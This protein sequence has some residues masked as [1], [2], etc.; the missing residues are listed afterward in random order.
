MAKTLQAK[1]RKAGRTAK[2][3]AGHKPD[4]RQSD[5][6]ASRPGAHDARNHQT[7]GDRAVHPLQEL[8][9]SAA[10]GIGLGRYSAVVA[11][12]DGALMSGSDPKV[13]S[14]PHTVDES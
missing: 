13:T 2:G 7:A 11:G 4:Y 10:P 1:P 14:C 12:A 6:T 5:P 3:V 9:A 8:R